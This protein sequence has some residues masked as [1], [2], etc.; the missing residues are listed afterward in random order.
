MLSGSFSS[1]ERS[2]P[3]S[4]PMQEE[5]SLAEKLAEWLGW[6]EDEEKLRQSIA[7]GIKYLQEMQKSIG[8]G[9]R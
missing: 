6:I 2:T 3:A 7:E 9:C 5:S 1:S 8:S 4:T